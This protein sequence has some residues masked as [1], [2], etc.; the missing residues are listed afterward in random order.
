M[1]DITIEPGTRGKQVSLGIQCEARSSDNHS[2]ILFVSIIY[3]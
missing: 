2:V 3:F 1:R